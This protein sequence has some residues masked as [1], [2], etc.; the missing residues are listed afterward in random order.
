MNDIMLPPPLGSDDDGYEEYPTELRPIWMKLPSAVAHG[1]VLY[2]DQR[3][4]EEPLYVMQAES[5]ID[6]GHA[7]CAKGELFAVK[8][9]DVNLD[10]YM[11][12]VIVVR[13][14]PNGTLNVTVCIS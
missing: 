14:K 1:L 7:T 10:K 13:V 11:G 2:R 4:P 3:T 5:A 8:A 12:K 6:C 9:A